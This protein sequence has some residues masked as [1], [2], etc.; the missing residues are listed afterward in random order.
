MFRHRW[1]KQLTGRAWS[2]ANFGD[3]VTLRFTAP[4]AAARESTC[5]VFQVQILPA[6]ELNGRRYPLR[7]SFPSNSSWGE[8]GWTFTNNWHRDSLAAALAKVEQLR[9]NTGRAGK[10]G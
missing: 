1:P 5:E 4:K 9:L 3:R 2:T 7:E 8:V 6:G 10:G